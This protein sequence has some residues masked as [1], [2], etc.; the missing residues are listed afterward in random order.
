[1]LRSI[2]AA[3]RSGFV[4]P[5]ANVRI[6]VDIRRA[7]ANGQ[8]PMDDVRAKPEPAAAPAVA[9]R[10]VER[11]I[12][13]LIRRCPELAIFRH[14]SVSAADDDAVSFLEFCNDAACLYTDAAREVQL[15]RLL[16]RLRGRVRS[17]DFQDLITRRIAESD[18]RSGL[19]DRAL[20][21][22]DDPHLGEQ[23][24]NEVS[25][26]D[27]QYGTREGYLAKMFQS[28]PLEG[29]ARGRTLAFFYS[30]HTELVSDKRILHVAPEKTL[31]AFFEQ[32]RSQLNCVYESLDGFS[33]ETNHQA[34]LTQIPLSNGSYDVVIC[35]RVLEH[36][37]DDLAAMAEL[38]RILAPGGLLDISVP[39]SMNRAE[40]IEWCSQ[41]TSHHMHVRQ[42]GR[43]FAQRLRAAG[44]DVTVDQ[45]LLE[46]PLA[47]HQEMKTFPMRHYLC[48]KLPSS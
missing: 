39:Q 46:M 26:F 47:R 30:G 33:M 44:F 28:L 6:A 22:R 27:R 13:A 20:I 17:A 19:V 32:R 5:I 29:D 9:H 1:M 14:S 48:R 4:L 36:V 25:E 7:R 8:L 12:E 16:A 40:T 41:D 2:L 43:D 31:R 10:I 3:L 11:H 35:H 42:Y 38:H 18:L 34:D 24:A 15:R 23:V 37:M 45:S 21:L